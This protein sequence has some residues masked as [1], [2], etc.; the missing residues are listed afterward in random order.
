[1]IINNLYK[2]VLKNT[3]DIEEL[4]EGSGG[5]VVESVNGK[6]G[7]VVLTA[8]DIN[9][10]NAQT[11]QQNLAR[12]DGRIDDETV[13]KTG[14]SVVEG[15]ITAYEWDG[16]N[17]VTYNTTLQPEGI[18]VDA[19]TD[20]GTPHDVLTVDENSITTTEDDDL[21]PLTINANPLIVK[22]GDDELDINGRTVTAK[23]NGNINN[24]D[25]WSNI[26][27]IN[28]KNVSINETGFTGNLTLTPSTITRTKSGAAG[29]LTVNASPLAVKNGDNEIRINNRTIEGVYQGGEGNIDVLSHLFMQ[30]GH[31][32]KNIPTPTANTDAANKK[33][34]DDHAGG[35]G[36]AT[37]ITSITSAYGSTGQYDINWALEYQEKFVISMSKTDGQGVADINI[38]I[39]GKTVPDFGMMIYRG[40]GGG[41]AS[42]LG[43]DPYYSGYDGEYIITLYKSSI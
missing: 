19:E 24:L 4:K 29:T 40:D 15:T 36:G 37:D 1:M 34:V 25:V 43:F 16:E 42:V 39:T 23:T 20:G 21:S 5:D 6:T 30:G 10:S 12:I 3:C 22:N 35:G 38:T 11:V 8:S 28:D 18:V 31:T 41:S 26:T 32:I 2:Q 27:L 14:D 9:A 17:N 33:Y 13:T 7:V